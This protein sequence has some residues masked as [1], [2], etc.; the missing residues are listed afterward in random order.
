MHVVLHYKTF[1]DIEVWKSQLRKGAAE[2]AILSLIDAAAASG[3]EL[4]DL[5]ARSPEVGL[6]D[7]A[8]Y[9]L[10]NRLEREG[11]IAGRWET[12]KGGGRGLKKYRLTADGAA[13]LRRMQAAWRLFR[14]DLDAVLGE[15]R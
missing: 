6:S 7:G 1:V 10:L 15:K 4:L 9:P 8:V 11:R 5:L 12:P 3:T 2:L 13:A 14:D